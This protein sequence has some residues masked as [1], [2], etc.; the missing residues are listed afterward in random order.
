MKSHKLSPPPVPVVPKPW[1][2]LR[3]V[4]KLP[5]VFSSWTQVSDFEYTF[6]R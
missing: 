2:V 6:A 4:G 5:G 3:F 1:Y